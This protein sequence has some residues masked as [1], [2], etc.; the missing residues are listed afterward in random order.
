MH[1]TKSTISPLFPKLALFL[2]I[3]SFHI[4][5]ATEVYR[6]NHTKQGMQTRRGNS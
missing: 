4:F 2:C 5:S 3:V 1:K 6:D